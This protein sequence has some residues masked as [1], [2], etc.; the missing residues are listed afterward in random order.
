[1]EISFAGDGRRLSH[2]TKFSTEGLPGALASLTATCPPPKE[3][4]QRDLL[5]MIPMQKDIVQKDMAQKDVAPAQTDPPRDSAA[6]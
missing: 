6:K 4:A 2:P 1:V 3:T 5:Q